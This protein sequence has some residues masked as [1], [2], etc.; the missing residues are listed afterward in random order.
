MGIKLFVRYK[1]KFI[2]QKYFQILDIDF[3]KTITSII[4]CKLLRI[5][6]AILALFGFLIKQ[7]NIV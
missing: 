1:A 6:L 7:I 5:F 3:N 2:A 4:R